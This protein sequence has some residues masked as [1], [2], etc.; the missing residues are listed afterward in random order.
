MTLMVRDEAD[1]IGPMIDHHLSQGVDMLIVTDNGSV[2]GTV[3]I[4]ESYGDA[5]D[6]RHDPV[7]RKQQHAV[8]TAMAR[9]AATRYGADWVVNADADEFWLPKADGASL[10]DVFSQLTPALRA[11][12]VPVIDMTGDPALRGTGLQRLLYRDTRPLERMNELGIHAHATPD[13]VHVGDPDVQISQGNHFVSIQSR[14]A[15]PAG[16]ELEVLHYP[17]R[18]WQQFQNKV[19]N[20]GRAYEANPD[21]QPSP[22]HHGMREYRRWQLGVLLPYYVLRHP[23]AT[24]LERGL[25]D[26]TLRR[27]DRIAASTASVVPDEP[28]DEHVLHEARRYG[29]ALSTLERQQRD[30][31]Q[32]SADRVAEL[33]QYIDD[34][35]H[36]I[37]GLIEEVWDAEGREREL[38][39]ELDTLRAELHELRSR[40]VVRLT[41][42]L[43]GRLRPHR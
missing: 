27:D 11:F 25:A 34:A 40:R 6:L 9:D 26:G 23:D 4:L 5:I 31:A 42:A 15:V 33:L 38:R 14:G 22:N 20:S 16:L 43:V 36:R 32:A 37:D 35:K 8:V 24:E 3:E 29:P 12:T 2:D 19:A 18:S 7:Q 39:A 28:L 10:H 1:V 41:D 30:Q 21:L 17:W 13:S